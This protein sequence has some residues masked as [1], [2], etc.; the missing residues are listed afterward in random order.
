[1]VDR[2]SASLPGALPRLFVVESALLALR[3][4]QRAFHYALAAFLVRNGHHAA[5]DLTIHCESA[6]CLRALDELRDEL[7][8]IRR[9]IAASMPPGHDGATWGALS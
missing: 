4:R 1:M 5:D 6:A 8:A 2:D 3:D 9:T 7:G